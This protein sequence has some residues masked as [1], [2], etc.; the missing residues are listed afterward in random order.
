MI[1][2]TIHGTKFEIDTVRKTWARIDK[3]GDSG[4]L[5]DESGVYYEMHPPVIGESLVLICPPRVEGAAGRAIIT[6][7]IKEIF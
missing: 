4:H 6:T 7:P 5:R 2:T 1:I 3:T